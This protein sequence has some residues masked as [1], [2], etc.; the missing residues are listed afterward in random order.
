MAALAPGTEGSQFFLTTGTAAHL[1]GE[2]T[3]FGRVLEGQEVVDGLRPGQ[4]LL[5]AEIVRLREGT[6]YHP[7]TTEGREAPTPR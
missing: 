6:N 4:R 1:E 2:Y 7:L 5:R 3:I